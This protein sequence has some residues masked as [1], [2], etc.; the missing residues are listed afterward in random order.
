M[1]DDG[2]AYG[3]SMWEFQIFG[4]PGTGASPLF[5]APQASVNTTLGHSVTFTANVTGAGYTYQWELNGTTIPGATGS[6]YT[7]PSTA[8]GNLGTYV[9]VVTG[10]YGSTTSNTFTL[11]VSTTPAN[12]SDTPTM[13]QWGLILLALSLLVAATRALKPERTA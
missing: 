4:Q 8:A 2:Q 9:V 5:T 13:P 12:P 3:Y 10:P 6:T 11:G 7:I 1:R